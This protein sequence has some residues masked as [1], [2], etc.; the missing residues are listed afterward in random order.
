VARGETP[1]ECNEA[2]TEQHILIVLVVVVIA[3]AIVAVV[4]AVAEHAYK[5]LGD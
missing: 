5:M 1:S 2:V 4:V 3:I